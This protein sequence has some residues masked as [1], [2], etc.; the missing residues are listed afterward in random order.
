MKIHIGVE[1]ERLVVSN[2]LQP[3][4]SVSANGIG[5][6]NLS[7]RCLL[8]TGKELEVD[9]RFGVFTVKIPFADE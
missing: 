4:K 6:K 7:R 1:G 5:L 2:L 9:E 3:K 8:I